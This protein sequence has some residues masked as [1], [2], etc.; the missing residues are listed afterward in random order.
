ML[1]SISGQD[2][3]GLM[4]A[5]MALI[6]KAESEILDMGQAVIHAELA[7][8]VLLRVRDFDALADEIRHDFESPGFAIRLSKVSADSYQQWAQGLARS[9]LILTLLAQGGGAEP[10]H[11]ISA[12]THRY[13]LN[14]DTVRRLTLPHASV[15]LDA[16]PGTARLGIE[17]RLGGELQHLETFQAEL[18]TVAN[19][20]G[21]DFSLQRDTVFRRNRRLV[22]FDMDSTLIAVEVMDELAKRYGVGAQVVEITAAA[23]AGQLDFQQSFRRRAAL[24]RG[25]PEKTLHEVATSVTLSSGAHRLIRALKHFGY[26]TAVLS[27]G[28]QYV[29]EHLQ[30]ELGIDYVFANRLEVVDGV[31]TGEV[32]GEIVD[33]QRKADLL[34]TLAQ[35]EGISLQQTIAVGDGANDLPMLQRAGLGVA[36]HAKSIVRE[37]ASHSISN[38]GLD[39]ILYL[40]GFN[41]LDVAQALASTQELGAG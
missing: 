26:R 31:M 8:S 23:M 2:K 16:D 40:I 35:R 19:A 29:G 39:A 18:L 36:Y 5:L 13:G 7:L 14:I 3:P 37:S 30:Q 32:V 9:P 11:A 20:I 10:V 41:D 15:A 27:G 4:A 12:L 34:L 28:F 6:V 21:F 33:A 17:M 25:M 1:V 22:A 38:F 24:L